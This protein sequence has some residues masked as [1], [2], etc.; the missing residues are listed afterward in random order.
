MIR[1]I[2]I[3]DHKSFY[4]V[5][6][7]TSKNSLSKIARQVSR[8]ADG[9]L[10]LLLPV[11]IWLFQA[12]DA[13]GLILTAGA[14]FLLE[15]GLYYLLKNTVRRKR[16][17]NALQGFKS[18]II[19][20]DE[21]SLPSGHTSAAFFVTIFLGAGINPIFL[22]LLPWAICVGASRVILGVHFITDVIIGAI[23]GASIAL[24]V[25]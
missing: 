11:S 10:Y 21:F 23:I 9:W 7:Y 25:L 20:S 15:R 4:S 13:P 18:L 1:Y 16:P 12:E 14:G 8:S 17:Y 22:I 19:A 6:S 24:L 3:L 5:F 2:Q